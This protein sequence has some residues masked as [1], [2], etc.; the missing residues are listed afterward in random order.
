VAS[1]SVACTAKLSGIEAT[2]LLVAAGSRARVNH[3]EVGLRVE[4]H[5]QASS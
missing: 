4:E 1:G 2:R 3:L 5:A